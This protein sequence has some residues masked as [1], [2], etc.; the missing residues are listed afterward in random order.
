MDRHDEYCDFV[1]QLFDGTNFKVSDHACNAGF[2]IDGEDVD[3]AVV[4]STSFDVTREGIYPVPTPDKVAARTIIK[5][6]KDAIPTE[7]PF[8]LK[9]VD[10][11][12][13]NN[14]VVG[15]GVRWQL[16]FVANCSESLLLLH[17][18]DENGR[19]I[20]RDLLPLF[21]NIECQYTFDSQATEI[22]KMIAITTALLNQLTPVEDLGYVIEE[23]YS[24]GMFRYRR[25]PDHIAK[26]TNCLELLRKIDLVSFEVQCPFCI[27]DCCCKE[28]HF[29]DCG[30]FFPADSADVTN[31]ESELDSS[32]ADLALTQP[33]SDDGEVLRGATVTSCCGTPSYAKDVP[34]M[35]PD[36]NHRRLPLHRTRK[37]SYGSTLS[38][39]ISSPPVE[40][41]AKRGRPYVG[42]PP[43]RGTKCAE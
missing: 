42:R 34:L 26:V 29:Q 2:T 43:D 27:F 35:Y 4:H 17:P 40:S 6:V 28:T 30:C 21:Y 10:Y 22:T 18:T 24:V 33:D 7:S 32:A 9:A 37:R 19:D 39:F 16:R 36:C 25:R 13:F 15:M 5:L 31:Q 14:T 41:P 23:M 20:G 3:L 11:I 12:Q 38:T 1:R 8:R